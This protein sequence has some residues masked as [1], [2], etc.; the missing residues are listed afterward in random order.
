[1][2]F[3]H[4]YNMSC[5]N[6]HGVCATA[7]VVCTPACVSSVLVHLKES[8]FSIISAIVVKYEVEWY[9]IQHNK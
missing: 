9:L 5:N 6:V 7:V 8:K 4:A 3:G 2:E 1:M